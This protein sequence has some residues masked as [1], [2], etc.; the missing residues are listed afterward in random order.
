MPEADAS[1]R[2]GALRPS[3]V[4]LDLCHERKH[5]RRSS[6]RSRLSELP[7][8]SPKTDTD[9]PLL[10]AAGLPS[11]LQ[12]SCLAGERGQAE[13]FLQSF[14][15]YPSVLKAFRCTP[16]CGHPSLGTPV[17]GGQ[18]ASR[19]RAPDTETG[20]VCPERSGFSAP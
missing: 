9:S 3:D 4:E 15:R 17:L 1:E 14:P 12:C 5:G 18:R 16:P 8:A 10:V 7:G 13:S 20:A 11:S 19:N 2:L 6:L